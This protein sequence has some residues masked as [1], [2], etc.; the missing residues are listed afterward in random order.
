MSFYGIRGT[1]LNWIKSYLSERKQ[2]TTYG[3]KQS[4]MAT[5]HC[6]VPQGSIL[7]P[8]LF[9]I[10]VNDLAYVSPNLFTIMFADDTNCF[11]TGHNLDDLTNQMNTELTGIVTW[12]KANKL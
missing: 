6:G 2:F 7:G 8:L 12:L 9:L 3:G 10:Y 11:M 5:V 1:P 4:R